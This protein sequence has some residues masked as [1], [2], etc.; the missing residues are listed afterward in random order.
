MKSKGDFAVAPLSGRFD[1]PSTP[2]HSIELSKCHTAWSRFSPDPFSVGG[3]EK[4]D[5]LIGGAV[6]PVFNFIRIL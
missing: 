5:V 3:L 6:S 4:I 2:S 1:G